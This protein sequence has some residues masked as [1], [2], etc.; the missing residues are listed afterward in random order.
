MWDG[1]NSGANPGAKGSGT[2]GA[3]APLKT[4]P[5]CLGVGT[6]LEY[7][8]LGC[9]AGASGLRVLDMLTFAVV[10]GRR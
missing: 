5:C 7:S 2:K 8:G 4:L 6:S 10:G 1:K 3:T 9:Q